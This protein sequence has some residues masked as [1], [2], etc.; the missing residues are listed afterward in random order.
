M[1]LTSREYREGLYARGGNS[2]AGSHE[3]LQEYKAQFIG[4]FV[5]LNRVSSVMDFGCGDGSFAASADLGSYTGV[6][7]S[8]SAVARNRER[9]ADRPSYRFHEIG[10]LANLSRHDMTLSLD[11][12][13]HLLEDATFE[14]Y[15]NNLF[16]FA[17]RFVI[18]YSSDIDADDP[19]PHIRHRNFTDFVRRTVP[20]WMLAA[21]IPNNYPYDPSDP[22]ET[23]FADFHVY[24]RLGEHCLLDLPTQ[25]FNQ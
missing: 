4:R 21:H 8:T 7:V 13:Y 6:D 3:R 19:T 11:V 14:Q 5:E 12:L 20:E 15:I 25:T 1:K 18:I 22:T 24:R 17:K 23:S 10:E 2:G 16:L 9:F